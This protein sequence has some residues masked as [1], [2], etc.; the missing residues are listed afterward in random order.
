MGAVPILFCFAFSISDRS[1]CGLVFPLTR[2]R[3][4]PSGERPAPDRR[5]RWGCFRKQ[6]F[7][8]FAKS[9]KKQGGTLSFPR[10]KLPWE[11]PLF[12]PDS[13]KK[14]KPKPTSSKWFFVSASPI[15]TAKNLGVSMDIFYRILAEN[16]RMVLS[17]W[18]FG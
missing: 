4:L 18:P 13:A 1:S 8:S 10:R 14:E 9:A 7:A 11:K 17:F 12:Q 16:S 3:K 15:Q 2:W 5:L 6:D